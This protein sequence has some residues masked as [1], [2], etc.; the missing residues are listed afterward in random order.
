[1][2]KGLVSII[3]PVYNSEQ[4]LEETIQCVQKQ[5]YT[6]WEMLL[7]DDCSSDHSAEIIKKY[8]KNDHRVIY[9]KLD[10]NGGAAKARNHAL[11]RSQGQY[12]AYLDA[13]D[14]W[15][16][17]KL[18]RQIDFMTSNHVEF[19]CCDYEK[20]DAD[21]TKL[22]KVVHMPKTITYDQLLSNTIIQTVG[23]IVD[24]EMVDKDLLVMPDVRR[25]QDSATW[26]QMLRN[27]VKFNGQN[28]V[29]TQYRRVPQSL[30]SNKFNAMKRTWYL[31]RHVE[32]L[33][34]WK[35]VYCMVGWAY[36]ASIKRIY[37]MK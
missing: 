6:N 20:I 17:N 13:D 1:M 15:L 32:K 24:L 29:L 3:V 18:E 25:G 22:N 37:I 27:G 12:I 19:S 2:I 14:V 36:H 30:S 28:E 4:Y 33:P 9:L 35:S 11:E 21:G 7:A 16:P 26:L 31:Y 5:S 34:L 23:V 8:A 10:Q